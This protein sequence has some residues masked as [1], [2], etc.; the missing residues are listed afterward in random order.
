[1]SFSQR[2]AVAQILSSQDKITGLEGTASAGKTT[3]LAAIRDAAESEGYEVRGLAPTTRA[4][5]KLS[6]SGIASG[7][8]ERERREVLGFIVHDISGE[9]F[10]A[11]ALPL[12]L[13]LL[14]S[15]ANTQFTQ[16]ETCV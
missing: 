14:D 13:N 9:E 7:T 12:I 16:G 6:E 5:H 11:I 2:A 1:L 8:V 4:A 15:T 3:S 10:A